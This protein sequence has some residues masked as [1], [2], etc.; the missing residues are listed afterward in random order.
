MPE[1]MRHGTINCSCGQRF[2]FETLRTQINCIK[3]DKTHNISSYPEKVDE[4][5][6]SIEE[7]IEEEILEV[8]GD[9]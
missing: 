3:C 9:I 1:K 2:Y 4:V 6:E 7:P 8:E 5:E